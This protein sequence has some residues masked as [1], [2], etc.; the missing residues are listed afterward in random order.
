MKLSF[1]ITNIGLKVSLLGTNASQAEL[2][3]ESCGE[4]L[5]MVDN[6]RLLTQI[7]F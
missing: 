6:E 2:S 5:D 1:Q 7:E 3:F 4:G